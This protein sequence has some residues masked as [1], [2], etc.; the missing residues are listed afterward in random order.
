MEDM[1]IEDMKFSALWVMDCGGK[2]D[3]DGGIITIRSRYWPGYP[4]PSTGTDE[5]PSAV[6]SVYIRF[7]GLY[8]PDEPDSKVLVQKWFKADTEAEVKA[9]VEAWA[10]AQY[11][12]VAQIL[13]AVFKVSE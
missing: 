1:D 10:Q 6:S 12:K 3:Y 13:A 4:K 2:Q 11:M 8:G 7:R 9:Q 5:P